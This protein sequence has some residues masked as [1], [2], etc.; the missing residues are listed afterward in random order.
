[1]RFF[2]SVV[3]FA[4]LLVGTAQAADPKANEYTST[5]WQVFST[6]LYSLPHRA[7]MDR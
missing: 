7:G 1:M 3:S 2:A 5:D 4:V 6:Q